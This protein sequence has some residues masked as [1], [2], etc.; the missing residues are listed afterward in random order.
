M[1]LTQA[2][3]N[4]ED[5]LATFLKGSFL[6]L[7]TRTG[8]TWPTLLLLITLSVRH[9]AA[10]SLAQRNTSPQTLVCSKA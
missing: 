9:A 3:I 8:V 1:V 4:M 6:R 7:R 10:V 5:S 2:Y